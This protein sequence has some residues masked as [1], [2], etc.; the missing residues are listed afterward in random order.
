MDT[1]QAVSSVRS[2]SPPYPA[3]TVVLP[4]G[5]DG[6]FWEPT[7][8][9]IDWPPLPGV[10]VE[11]DGMRTPLFAHD[12]RITPPEAWLDL[13]GDREIDLGIDIDELRRQRPAV[14]TVLSRPE[15]E[16]AVRAALK[17]AARSDA[18]AG[19]PLL[20]SRL[21]G[22]AD[23]DVATRLLDL[24]ADA[25]DALRAAPQGDKLHR[26]VA[27]TFFKGIATQ[28]AAAERLGLPFSTYRR[29]LAAGIAGVVAHL[30]EREVHGPAAH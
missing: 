1:V 19:N 27:T 10:E 5:L 17:D 15:F 9:Y 12:W 18:L 3:L 8:T 23:D 21:V 4:P 14:R 13:M 2:I 11:I 25:V 6:A 24:L 28:E 26:A 7:M 30:W 16:D 22:V 29:H 20:Q